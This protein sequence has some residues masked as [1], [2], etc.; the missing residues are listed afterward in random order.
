VTS[1]VSPWKLR[2]ISSWKCQQKI[3]PNDGGDPNPNQ[4]IVKIL[5]TLLAVCSVSSVSVIFA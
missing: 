2:R 5:E 4:H 1:L 3:G